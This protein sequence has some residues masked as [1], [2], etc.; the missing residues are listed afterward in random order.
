MKQPSV[1][2]KQFAVLSSQWSG[3][4]RDGRQL[5]VLE[6]VV[7]ARHENVQEYAGMSLYIAEYAFLLKNVQKCETQYSNYRSAG[8]TR[9]TRVPAGKGSRSLR[10]QSHVRCRV[11]KITGPCQLRPSIFSLFSTVAAT[12]SRSRCWTMGTY[13]LAATRLSL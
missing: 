12:P 1:V 6:G 2:R 8:H 5:E 11:C 13:I 4:S 9:G 10:R 7:D 3:V